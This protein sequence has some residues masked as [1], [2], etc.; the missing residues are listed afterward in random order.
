MKGLLGALSG[1]VLGGCVS[2]VPDHARTHEFDGVYDVAGYWVREWEHSEETIWRF[3]ADQRGI[4]FRDTPQAFKDCAG[5]EAA[6]MS[7][8]DLV[9]AAERFVASKRWDDFRVALLMQRE[10]LEDYE[11][12]YGMRFGSR[13]EELCKDK[14]QT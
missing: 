10:F 14:I 2:G 5:K 7:P 8:P 12:S 1:A 9:A 3:A 13:V 4:N 11:D 6:R